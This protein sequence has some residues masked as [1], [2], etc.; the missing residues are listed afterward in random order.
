MTH[1]PQYTV[2]AR[3]NREELMLAV[4]KEGLPV[5]PLIYDYDGGK[6]LQVVRLKV[7]YTREPENES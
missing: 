5:G 2:I 6:V 7:I 4:G 3:E 1:Q